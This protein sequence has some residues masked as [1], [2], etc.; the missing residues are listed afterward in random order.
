MPCKLQKNYPG[1]DVKEITKNDELFRL[2]SAETVKGK[3]S[4]C[5]Q[6]LPS[7]KWWILAC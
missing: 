7:N 6:L 4:I 2:I 1:R 3:Y 5:F